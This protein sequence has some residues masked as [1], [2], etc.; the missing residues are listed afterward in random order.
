MLKSPLT[1]VLKTGHI[2]I[3]FVDTFKAKFQNCRAKSK[4]HFKICRKALFK[5][6]IE[7]SMSNF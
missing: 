4:A 3:E 7:E 1:S 5:I 2:K 6:C